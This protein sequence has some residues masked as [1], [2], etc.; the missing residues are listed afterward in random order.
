MS[1]VWSSW[2]VRAVCAGALA[3]ACVGCDEDTG[4]G[5]APVRDAGGDGGGGVDGGGGD[6]VDR[7]EDGVGVGET[8]P[9]EQDCDDRDDAR[10]PGAEEVCADRKDNDCDGVVDETCACR[11]GELRRCSSHVADPSTLA[12]GEI[13]CKA[14]VQR[15][16][17]GAWSETCEGEIGPEE[18]SCNL[19]DDDCDGEVDEGERTPLGLCI[20]DLP[21]DYMPPVES[22]GPTGEGNGFDEDGDGEVDEDC[23]C[24]VPGFD[25]DLPRTGQP[26]YSGAPATLGVGAC[27]GGTRSCVSGS[28]E[29]CEGDVTPVS[30]V[31]GDFEDNDCD[32]IVDE[33]CVVCVP[34]EADEETSCDGVDNDCDGVIDE[35]LRNACGG[36]GEV[37]QTDTCNN[38]LDDDCDGEV[39]EGCAC[40]QNFQECYSGPAEAAGVGVC[41][42]GSQGCEDEFL[43][44]CLGSVLPGVEL[45]GPDGLGNG[46]D[47][48]CDGAVDEGCG[49]VE[50]STRPCGVSAGVCEYG[51]QTCAGGSWGACANVVGP[52]EPGDEVTCDG[53]DNDCDGVTDEGLLNA[54]GRCGQ[55]CYSEDFD[56]ATDGDIAE[57][58]ERIDANAPN[59]PTG[60]SGV[61]L[62]SETTFLPYLWAANHDDDTTSKFNTDTKTEDARYWTGD[63]PSRTAVDLDGNMWVI[64]RNDGRVTKIYAR[65]SDCVDRVRSDGLPA[66]GIIQTSSNINGVVTVVNSAAAPLDDECVAYS[67]QPDPNFTSGRGVAI[68][69]NGG[70]WVGYSNNGGAIQKIDPY[71]F[72][73]EPSIITTSIPLMAPDATGAL[74]PVVDGAGVQQTGNFGRIYGMVGDSQGNLFLSGLFDSHTIAQYDVNAGQWVAMY[75]GSRCATY[76]IAVDGQD[77]IWAGCGFH[78]WGVSGP[79]S[80]QGGGFV[81]LDQSTNSMHRFYAPA[82]LDARANQ[83]PNPLETLTT[84]YQTVTDGMDC[85]GVCADTFR[86]TALAV[87]PATGD[88][89]GAIYAKGYIGRLIVDDADY[90]QS[91]WRFIPALREADN[92]PIAS[93]YSGGMRGVG[94]DPTGTAWYL[95]SGTDFVFEIDPTPGAEARVAQYDVG[96]GSHYTYSDF[97][98]ASLFNFTAPRGLWR[99]YFD[100]SFDGAAVDSIR[101]EA[102]APPGTLARVRVRAVDPN[103]RAP[104]TDWRPAPGAGGQASYF[105]YPEGAAMDVIDLAGQGGLL[106]GQSFEVEVLLTTTDRDVR[107]IVHD[108]ALGWQRP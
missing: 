71:T 97:T 50:L 6:C 29:A 10:Y 49:C 103:T 60:R 15:C 52:T 92:S 101:W 31:C 20:D 41:A 78:G 42:R 99:T 80:S 1:P 8:C 13:R 36:C 12:G 107:P 43:A 89:W 77:R 47:E 96:V 38:G 85:A 22:C 44:E 87:E 105:D 62:S 79:L 2:L 61:S 66:D 88:I 108:I 67:G 26:C 27:R 4:G 28:W 7:D 14:G 59:N 56:T 63:N 94:F 35:N 81:M 23:S 100:T 69:S 90:A 58:A 104:L 93:G 68:D 55:S 39:D 86:V 95:G 57:G 84:G 75:T 70:L 98:G 102:Y 21:P 5:E 65:I 17:A 33:G 83:L 48:D 73:A 30:E 18:E 53:L 72:V 64:G 11:T 74:Q 46:E 24:A 91:T 37:A 32:G 40:I 16:E 45:C 3:V 54:C 51:V 9:G 82:A 34:T 19:I 76:G 106:V 25:P